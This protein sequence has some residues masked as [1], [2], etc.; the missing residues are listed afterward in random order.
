[1]TNESD[2]QQGPVTRPAFILCEVLGDDEDER[3]DFLVPRI[4]PAATHQPKIFENVDEAI[5]YAS[6]HRVLGSAGGLLVIV[7]LDP[8]AYVEASAPTV[9]EIK[10][11]GPFGEPKR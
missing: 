8:V 4:V 10:Q 7:R 5:R 1:M 2:Q 3:G 9:M 6:A 11:R